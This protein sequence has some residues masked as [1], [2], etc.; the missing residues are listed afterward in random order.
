MSKLPIVQDVYDRERY[1]MV[2][3]LSIAFF[4]IFALL[5]TLFY[6][7][8]PAA[9]AIY[10]SVFFLSLFSIIWL[11]F[12]RK[13]KVVFWIFTITASCLVIYSVN[14]IIHT[15]HY[16]DLLWIV[17]IVL[18]AYVGLSNR[19]ALFF[20]VIHAIALA[21]FCIFELNKHLEIVRP[22]SSTELVVT[23]IEILFAFFVMAYL[24][25]ANIRFQT[26]V[27][28]ELKHSNS[29]LEQKNNEITTLLKEVHHRVKNN[30][31]IVVSLLRIQ[32]AE[33]NSEEL[34]A[35]FQVAVNRVMT[36]STIHQKLYQSKELSQVDFNEYINSLIAD[37]QDLFEHRKI[38]IEFTSTIDR[39]DLK[40]IVPVGLI[41]N[42]LITNSIKHAP[43]D[44]NEQ[45]IT[46]QFEEG[47]DGYSQL[48][49]SD[50]H[51]WQSQNEGFGLELIA[52][53]TEQLEG[54]IEKENG[55]LNI[56]FKASNLSD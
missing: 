55:T 45:V 16:S 29:E 27:Q 23:S 25:H 26:F 47:E 20:V 51:V 43:S 30:L 35:Q 42:E 17:N 21:Y 52:T 7:S 56:R 1:N 54:V 53:L 34:R 22:L 49:Y 13:Y 18:F 38:K 33:L 32:Q 50:G 15:M 4:F 40:S 41:L 10:L 46:L 19:E 2:W 11:K 14:T 9:F 5:T 37:F 28:E 12:S 8:E 24:Y 6:D 3:R 36:I 48:I 44:D 31:Q 39:I